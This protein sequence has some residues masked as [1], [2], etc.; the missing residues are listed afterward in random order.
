MS[1]GFCHADFTLREQDL[2]TV[3]PECLTRV[4]DRAK[5]CHHCGVAITPELTAGEE[6]P[7]PCPVCGPDRHLVSRRMGSESVTVLECD[8]CAGIWLGAE[9]FGRLT[10]RATKQSLDEESIKKRP[11][12]AG[13]AESQRWKYRHCP[14]CHELMQ[15][16]NYGRQSGVIIDVC[17][18]DGFWFDAEELPRILAWIRRGGLRAAQ[19]AQDEQK[20]AAEQ[21]QRI[22]KAGRKVTAEHAGHGHSLFD[23]D[24]GPADPWDV[25]ASVV[26]RLFR[27]R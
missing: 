4:S 27:L 6:S 24:S 21:T 5:F 23:D 14:V 2:R 9:T 15:R 17:R 13:A 8:R 7:L 1:C 20:K 22:A 19:R 25:I 10:E 3:C 11:A 16:R 18:N 12:S 26:D